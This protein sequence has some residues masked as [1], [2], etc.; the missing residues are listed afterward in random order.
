MAYDYKKEFRELYQPGKTPAIVG[1]P[2]MN[3]VAVPGSG[4]PNEENGEY[5]KAVAV[6]YAISYTIR[7]SHKGDHAIEGYFEYTV[8]PLEGLWWQD[9]GSPIDYADKSGFQ[10]LAMIR[11]PDFV[12]EEDFVWAKN[13]AE[14]K[15]KLD[16]VKAEFI[17]IDEGLCV[18]VM[19][20][21]SYDDEPETIAAMDRFAEEQGYAIDISD[22]R[23]HHE[24]YLSDPRKVA[25]ERLKTVL[26]H[27]VRER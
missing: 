4:D 1:V 20:V 15:K 27:P 8:P 7:M 13:E 18:Q 17:S 9:D 22:T 12:T 21:G 5:K 25:P 3:F 14:R 23:R 19:H 16:C 2:A 11:L 24:I 26:R 10:W 6:L